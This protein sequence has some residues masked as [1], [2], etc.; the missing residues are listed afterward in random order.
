MPAP[1]WLTFATTLIGTR[2]I[3]GP[4]HSPVIMAWVKKLGAKILG[5]NVT[6]DETPWCGTAMAHVFNECGFTPPKIAV[7]AS[8]WGSWG[9]PLKVAVPGAVLVFQRPGGGHVGLYVRETKDAYCVRGGNQ[10][11][12]FNDTW[13]EKSRCVAIRWPAG[14]PLPTAAPV[15]VASRGAVSKNEA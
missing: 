1:K 10:S 12:A 14:A 2:E 13:I 4:K 11:N 15:V 3:V 9:V 5:I 6:D 8:A 7:R